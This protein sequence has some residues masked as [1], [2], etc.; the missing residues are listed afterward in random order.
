MFEQYSLGLFLGIEIFWSYDKL[1]C[2]LI[3]FLNIF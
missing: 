1:F 2:L 3:W